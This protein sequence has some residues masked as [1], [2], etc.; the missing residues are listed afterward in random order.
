MSVA[1]LRELHASGVEIGAHTVSHPRLGTLTAAAA[2]AEIAGSKAILERVLGTAVDSFAYP[3]GSR[4]DFTVETE[5]I[6]RE[7]GYRRAC[8]TIERLTGPDVDPFTLGRITVYDWDEED[9]AYIL[10]RHWTAWRGAVER[11]LPAHQQAS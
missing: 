8:S 7:A 10:L 1:Q 6:V 4:A 11:E 3:F 5:S 2:R 9:F